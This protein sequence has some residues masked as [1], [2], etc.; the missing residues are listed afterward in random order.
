[1][2]REQLKHYLDQGLSL[3]SIGARVNRHPATISYWLKKHDLRPV[4]HK[5]VPKGPP[6]R[7]VLEQ[8]VHAGAT[9]RVIA[10]EL[11]ADVTTARR[12]L[13]R[14]DLRTQ[15]AARRAISQEARSNGLSSIDRTCPR[16]GPAEFVIDSRGSFRGR[17]CR[18][19][20]VAKRRRRLKEILVEEAGGCCHICGYSRCVAALEFHHVDPATKKFGLATRGLTRSLERCR[21]EAS[22]CVLL[23]ATCHAEVEAGVA[24]L[25]ET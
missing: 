21:K 2:D 11:D 15:G 7:T 18:A 8:L 6:P 5:Y 17:R 1:M 14:Y 22:K 24:L 19:E 9:L 3:K 23:C 10:S 13:D 12:W 25:S 4:G 20:A 16:H